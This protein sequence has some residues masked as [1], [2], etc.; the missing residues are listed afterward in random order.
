M[1][2]YELDI[3]LFEYFF[4]KKIS[5]GKKSL[6]VFSIIRKDGKQLKTVGYVDTYRGSIFYE[7][8]IA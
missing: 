5:H 8:M 7:L 2:I 1:N 4:G 3:S 6:L